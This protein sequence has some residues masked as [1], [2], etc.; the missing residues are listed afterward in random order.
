MKPRPSTN[1]KP[2]SPCGKN[3]MADEF[4]CRRP[5]GN[6]P[7]ARKI[8]EPAKKSSNRAT[9]D[10]YLRAGFK[11]GHIYEFIY[12][13]KNPLVL[14]LGFAVV[15]DLVSFLRFE[16]ERPSRQT[17]S[18][19]YIQARRSTLT[20]RFDIP[21]LSPPVAGGDKEGESPASPRL[22]LG[23]LPER[24]LSA[25]LRLPRF[26]RRRIR[27][28]SIRRHRAPCRRRRPAVFELRIRPPGHIIAATHQPARS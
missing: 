5:N 18:A 24:P 17:K 22:R 15:R 1:P 25:R 19:C 21:P 16:I 28:K 13:A 11:P 23:P 27:P 6:L 9:Q 12:P 14:G 8:R 2:R 26:Q 10:L 7:S 3:P 4:P 20:S